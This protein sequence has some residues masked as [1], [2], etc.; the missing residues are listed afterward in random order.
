[1][2]SKPAVWIDLDN[3]PHVPLFAPIVRR[4]RELGI[5]VL[6]TARDHSQTVELLTLHE[7]RRSSTVIGVHAGSNKFRKLFGTLKRARGLAS[8]VRK[9]R[10]DVKVAV[11]HGSR[12]MVLAAKFLRIPII[13][14]YDYEFTE[15]KVFNLLSDRVLVPEKIPVAAL[16]AIGL[17][18]RK[19]V[20]YKGYKEEIYLR[21]FVPDPGFWNQFAARNN[22]SIADD[23]V[24][25]VVRP[26]ADSANYHSPESD[27]LFNALLNRISTETGATA[28]VV[29][30]TSEQG[31]AVRQS[32]AACRSDG[33]IVILDS[34]QNG[35][36]LVW[37]A[38]IL[39]SGGGT[40]NREA[41]LLGVP[42]YSIFAGRQGALDADM[43]RRGL[44]KFIRSPEDVKNIKFI[45]R[46]LSEKPSDLGHGNL[47][48]KI[49][50]LARDFL[51]RD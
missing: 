42:V 22:L 32:A 50:E 10:L 24:L 36:D 29:P 47:Q 13:T 3:S 40:M 7:L 34:A 37:H 51:Q 41:A 2:P 8:L 35:L 44:I 31:A 9:S 20:T 15:T 49:I 27:D 17:N 26:P 43:E 33:R 18:P 11:S 19:R 23:E 39:V 30:R 46:V 28:I 16:D 12:S 25:V 4:L 1:M 38:D 5:E 48:D 21:G 45:K 14:A 6:L